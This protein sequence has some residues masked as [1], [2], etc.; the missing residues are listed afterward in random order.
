MTAAAPAAQPRGI[1][2]GGLRRRLKLAQG[3]RRLSRR[4]PI[5]AELEYRAVR[6]DGLPFRGA[7]RSLNLS[8]GGILF[9]SEQALTLGMRIELTI[10]WP[11]RLNDAVDLNLC[12]S[13]RVARTDG[14]LYVVRIREH[15]FCV[16]GRFRLAGPRFRATEPA[17]YAKAAAG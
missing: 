16:R 14:N 6:R 10:A 5:A 7:G 17:A 2:S 13:G 12:V 8:T 11:A 3:D 4:Y 15:E 1:L 9:Q